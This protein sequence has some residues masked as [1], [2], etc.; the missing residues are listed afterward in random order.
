MYGIANKLISMGDDIIS[1]EAIDPAT[2]GECALRLWY[3]GGDGAGHRCSGCPG[4]TEGAK[5][6]YGKDCVKG[7]G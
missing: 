4:N 3:R 2:S 1:M 5:A 6:K 7:A